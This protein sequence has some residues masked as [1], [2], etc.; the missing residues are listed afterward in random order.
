M[1][2]QQK[3]THFTRKAYK[4]HH[5]NFRGW[6]PSK[7]FICIV[8]IDSHRWQKK[9]QTVT[10][11]CYSKPFGMAIRQ[12]SGAVGVHVISFKDKSPVQESG[13]EIG[14]HLLSVNGQDCSNYDFQNV[15]NLLLAAK[16][17]TTLVFE[18]V[19]RRD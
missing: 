16:L 15:M 7:T 5:K 3:K 11:L 12:L 17:P 4:K 18:Y 1:L 13:I 6:K 9:P 14:S 2:F 19:F 10:C 8:A